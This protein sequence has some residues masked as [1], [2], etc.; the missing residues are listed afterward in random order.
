M[1]AKMTMLVKKRSGEKKLFGFNFDG[2]AAVSHLIEKVAN[3]NER[4]IIILGAGGA[5]RAIAMAILHRGYSRSIGLAARNLAATDLLELVDDLQNLPSK[6]PLQEEKV[7]VFFNRKKPNDEREGN[8][9]AKG[10]S[11]KANYKDTMKS[12]NLKEALREE[13]NKDAIIINTTPVGML[14]NTDA[15]PLAG[16]LI[17]SGHV[18]YDI[19]YNPAE[20]KLLKLAKEKKCHHLKW[21][22]HVFR[23]GQ[24]A[25]GS[26]HRSQIDT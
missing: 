7:R 24:I 3:W 6:Y 19:I 18:V 23:A 26:I 21:F 12:Q 9:N 17:S 1:L 22:W 5:A 11:L 8:K 14:P 25:I 13:R 16:E 20:T 4:N 2:V 15:S 10:D